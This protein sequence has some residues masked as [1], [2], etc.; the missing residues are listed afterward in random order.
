MILNEDTRRQISGLL[1][2]RMDGYGYD[3][4]LLEHY[5]EDAGYPPRDRGEFFSEHL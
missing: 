3:A 1:Y 2:N 4:A 5:R